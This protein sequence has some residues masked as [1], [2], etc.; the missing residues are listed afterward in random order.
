[1]QAAV[2]AGTLDSARFENRKK[3][4]REQEFL[5]RKVDPAA[6]SDEKRRIKRLTEDVREIY[7]QKKNR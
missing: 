2:Q 4:L 5:R 1:V 6:R 3:L 7:K